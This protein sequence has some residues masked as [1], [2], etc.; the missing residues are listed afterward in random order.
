MARGRKSDDPREQ[1]VQE[2]RRIVAQ[3]LIE[4]EVN[5]SL[6][7]PQIP[8][9]LVNPDFLIVPKLGSLVTIDIQSLS[10]DGKLWDFV[11]AKIEDLFEIKMSTGAQTVVSIILFQW[12]ET[13]SSH[14][15]I[16]LLERLF[17]RVVIISLNSNLHDILP[18][19]V[20]ELIQEPYSRQAL[21]YL[22]QSESEARQSN[23]ERIADLS[24]VKNVLN[25]HGEFE[26][27]PP[28]PKRQ[29]SQRD[30]FAV[31]RTDYSLEQT[32]LDR[33]SNEPSFRIQHK[34]RV[35]NMKQFFINSLTQYYFTFDFSFLPVERVPNYTGFF[36]RQN[37]DQLF[38]N[39]GGLG[40]IISGSK[41][42]FGRISLLRKLATY[43]RFISYE[44]EE[45]S[46]RLRLR[47]T[48][49]RLYLLIDGNI[50]GPSYAPDRYLNML[51]HAGW[52]PMNIDD[53]T[54]EALLE[55]G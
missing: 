1:R 12:D 10:E 30:I 18:N 29:T 54:R 24:F 47:N 21:N 43:A 49:P 11:L 46:Q 2:C 42:S 16:T 48:S 26:P 28:R 8:E 13:E 20:R 38:R 15:A 17:D 35:M 33:L 27:K 34:P 6:E 3:T 14:D 22:W 50:F 55:G 44:P 4:L 37:L 52:R 5:D 40:Y 45:A 9:V 19:F 31:E 39:R 7:D 32:V 25:A 41:G 53:L 23:F 51:I 36:D